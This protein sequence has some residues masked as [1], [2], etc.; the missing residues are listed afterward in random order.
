MLH[1]AVLAERPM[2]NITN[3][4]RGGQRGAQ[5]Q[6]SCQ[7]IRAIG[8]LDLFTAGTGSFVERHASRHGEQSGVSHAQ[9]RAMVLKHQDGH[10]WLTS[11]FIVGG[12]LAAAGGLPVPA[13]F[14]GA[15]GFPGACGLSFSGGLCGTGAFV[16][17]DRA[18]GTG[19]LSAGGGRATALTVQRVRSCGSKREREHPSSKK[20]VES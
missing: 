11:A 10:A 1:A 3:I 18:S 5:D 9:L 16:C 12:V 8:L 13:R 17:A 15:R 2:L 7:P 14:S 19:R 20:R 4:F 6:V